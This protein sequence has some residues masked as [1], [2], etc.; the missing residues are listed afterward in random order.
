MAHPNNRSNPYIGPRAFD[1]GEKLFGRDREISELVNILIPERIVL[2][3]SPSGAGKTSLIQAGLI[4]ILGKE[5]FNVLPIVRVNMEPS[6][7]NGLN[8]FNRY[9]YSSFISL[10]ENLHAE[11]QTPLADL[12]RTSLDKYLNQRPKPDQPSNIFEGTPQDVLIFDQFEEVITLDPTDLQSKKEFFKQLGEALRDR[13]IWALFSMR[14]D[15]IAALDPYSLEIPTH[16]HRRYRLDLLDPDQARQAIQQPAR[17]SGIVFS[18]N[19]AQELIDDLR[20]VQVQLPDGRAV[21]QLG[22][23]VEPVQLQ[24]VC[25]RL[26]HQSHAEQLEI[27]PDDISIMGDVNQSLAAYY[28]ESIKAIAGDIRVKERHIREWFER[29]LIT[30]SR[31]RGQVLMG[32]QE[33]GGLDNNAIFRL[34]D[35]H[36][37]RSEKRRGAT[38]FELS[39]DRLIKPILDNNAGWF[40]KNLSLLQR[41][42]A[43]WIQQNRRDE[44][45][46][47]GEALA[48]ALEWAEENSDE[49]SNE[50]SDFID[51]CQELL[52]RELFEQESQR[53]QLELANKL[54]KEQQERADI[55]TRRANEQM[56]AARR[57][58]ARNRIISILGV[59]A[60]FLMIIA[61]IIAYNAITQT[62]IA[63]IRQLDS[64]VQINMDKNSDLAL[65]LG[66]EAYHLDR[67]NAEANHALL[68]ALQQSPQLMAIRYEHNA[69]VK[70]IA[71]QPEIDNLI[72]IDKDAKMMLWDTSNFN[73]PNPQNIIEIDVPEFNIPALSPDGKLLAF[74]G[75]NESI[76]L[77]DLSNPNQPAPINAQFAEQ[78]ASITSLALISGGKIFVSGDETG[79]IRLWDL[80]DPARPRPLGEVK[81]NDKVWSLAINPNNKIMASGSDNGII[82]LWDLSD[83]NNLNPLGNQFVGHKGAVTALAFSLNGRSLAT[84][85]VD[86]TI[87]LWDLSK[88]DAPN[89][90]DLTLIGHSG[91]VDSLAFSPDGRSLVSGGVD[92]ALY[93]WTISDLPRFAM[94]DQI[95]GHTGA[96][97]SLTYSPDG[98]TLVV[99][100]RDGSITLWDMGNP[101]SPS[102]IDTPPVSHKGVVQ[103]VAYSP[104]GKILATG[105]ID[106]SIMLWDLSDPYKPIQYGPPLLGH[107]SAVMSLAFSPDNRMMASGS[108]DGAIAL[109]DVSDP[110]QTIQLGQIDVYTNTINSIAFNKD[111]STLTSG[112]KDGTI[113]FWD[114]S[115]PGQPDQLG[116]SHK[117]YGSSNC[118]AISKDNSFAAFGN[119]DGTIELWNLSNPRKPNLYGSRFIGHK[120]AVKTLAV[121][122]NG[123]TLA[124]GGEDGIIRLWDLS[125]LDSPI[126]FDYP[127]TGH[128]GVIYSIA[129]SPEGGSLVSGGRDQTIRLWEISGAHQPAKYNP[130]LTGHTKG[131][132]SL[133]FSPVDNIFATVSRD[134]T[135]RLWSIDDQQQIISLSEV[136][137]GIGEINSIMFSPEGKIIASGS[138]EGVILLFDVSDPRLPSQISP[139]IISSESEVNSVTFNPDGKILAAGNEDGTILL[140]EVSNPQQPV[141]ISNR[142]IKHTTAVNSVTFSPEGEIL[143][144]G[145]EQGIIR[146]WSLEELS[147]LTELAPN[148]GTVRSLAFSPV[149]ELLATTHTGSGINLWDVSNPREPV[150]I[151]LT[152]SSGASDIYSIA[153]NYDGTILASGGG[154]DD[155]IIMLWDI[156]NPRQPTPLGQIN[157]H[158]DVIRSIAFNLDAQILASV[159][160]DKS[161]RLWY[162]NADVW[163]KLAC[164]RANRNLT[165]EEWEALLDFKG[166]EETC[167]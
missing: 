39:H 29:K 165:Q 47:R 157:G 72:S 140:W 21:E 33:S 8:D 22:A 128:A 88:P 35:T 19:A 162:M 129:F 80:N 5:G 17:E 133:D 121:T 85:G 62:R 64:Q 89:E 16:F 90:L 83:P 120:G 154:Y 106:Q 28:A 150:Q 94:I 147:Q 110:R 60:F 124:T 102:P 86:E 67:N 141:Q 37:V 63:R 130:P 93:I 144:S 138:E 57:L 49:L 152:L 148:L 44:L 14:E 82:Q 104:N 99:G 7:E 2:L 111:G 142:S 40:E 54:A 87:H 123:N 20:K 10:E 92:T 112:S 81:I 166:F 117:N 48:E 100:E 6:D 167:P 116:P 27:T 151:G 131:V 51:K 127:L 4:P 143:A 96:V 56:E 126:R 84:G 73:K 98:S 50:E 109:W 32:E 161:I 68:T 3:Y 149:G 105:G 91:E 78:S 18:D 25:Y 23:Y 134:Q 97:E 136:K 36:L 145:D 158:D 26:W 59:V 125:N 146:I 101:Q 15:Y 74:V 38:W 69:H 103:I 55:E 30:E 119:N 71:F 122:M 132:I 77:W 114:V 163:E 75:E 24:V 1:T 118:V 66:V 52:E 156:K 155:G 42:A 45:L 31:F 53:Q 164:Q 76:M 43:L 153:F 135:I 12:Q 58:E 115:N 108:F 159:G 61:L 107:T 160:G 70:G 139:N 34:I 65:L 137:A 95:Y 41:Q 13:N 79:N 9:L 11:E 113:V 46:L